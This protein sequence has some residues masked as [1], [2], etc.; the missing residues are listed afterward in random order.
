[1]NAHNMPSRSE[2]VNRF[3][4]IDSLPW[5]EIVKFDDNALCEYNYVSSEEIDALTNEQCDAMEARDNERVKRKHCGR[6]PFELAEERDFDVSDEPLWFRK[7]W[8]TDL[9]RLTT[10]ELEWRRAN[11]WDLGTAEN[12]IELPDDVEIDGRGSP[13]ELAR[14]L[15]HRRIHTMTRDEFEA[16]YA[17]SKDPYVIA[18]GLIFEEYD[19]EE[20]AALLR[21]APK[22]E[23]DALRAEFDARQDAA[24]E[25]S[26]T[27]LANLI[28]TLTAQEKRAVEAR[29]AKFAE[30][31]R[32][33]DE[34][35]KEQQV[36]Q[37]IPLPKPDPTR[38]YAALKANDRRRAREQEAQEVVRL[39]RVRIS[40]LKGKNAPLRRW[41]VP[42]FIPMRNVTNPT[43]DGGVGKS[44]SQL[45]LGVAV[46]AKLPSW[47]GLP[48]WAPRKIDFVANRGLSWSERLRIGT[49]TNRKFDD[50]LVARDR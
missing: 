34:Q 8:A 23:L 29:R 44:L 17:Y 22:S 50:N 10:A 28:A 43:G 47:H 49:R 7:L 31:R 45:Q 11:K 30:W 13:S 46:A 9:S 14:T 5:Q 16:A 35:E 18:H 1:V 2:E 3:T 36:A 32:K 15:W 33:N 40:E 6:D 26:G 38:G 19:R 37:V 20:N 4:I 12:P 39:P 24:R 42:D 27:E 25:L 41:L 48:L 21:R